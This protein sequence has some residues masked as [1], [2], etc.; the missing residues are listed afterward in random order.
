MTASPATIIPRADLPRAVAA[1]RLGAVLFVDPR[2]T[3]EQTEKAGALAASTTF[4][5]VLA[6]EVEDVT[7]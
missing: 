5:V 2:L 1:L 3:A 4:R 6:N 7:A